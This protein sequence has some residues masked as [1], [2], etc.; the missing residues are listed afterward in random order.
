MKKT[1]RKNS[2]LEKTLEVV[3]DKFMDAQ[4]EMEERYLDLEEKKM[5]LEAENEN[6]LMEMEEKRREREL[7]LWQMMIQ[8]RPQGYCDP[9]NGHAMGPP[10][11]MSNYNLDTPSNTHDQYR[12][13]PN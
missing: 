10:V 8:T 12:N 13:S 4:K 7:Q 3:V 11:Y 5:K 2:Q 6:K 1:R 9:F